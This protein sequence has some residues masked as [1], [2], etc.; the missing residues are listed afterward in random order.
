V[1]TAGLGSKRGPILIQLPPS[2][3][4]ASRLAKVFFA[5]LREEYDGAVVCEP[6]HASWFEPEAEAVL[7]AHRIGRVATDPTRIQVARVAG[8]WMGDARKSGNAVAY[9]RLHGSPRK[10]WSRYDE[11]RLREWAT[12]ILEL[13][14]RAHVW[15][16]FDN[17]A[18]GAAL[19]NALEMRAMITNPDAKT[20]RTRDSTRRRVPSKHI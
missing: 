6:R 4:Y 15:C 1:Q 16:I 3:E 9:Y 5:M 17:T 20:Q 2:L 8:G 18:S 14:R 10:Y 11:P 13:S 7:T 12:S 19:A